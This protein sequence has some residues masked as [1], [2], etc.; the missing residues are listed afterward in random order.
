MHWEL[1]TEIKKNNIKLLTY[2]NWIEVCY[3]S[4]DNTTLNNH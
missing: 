1:I 4:D 3:L 2:W